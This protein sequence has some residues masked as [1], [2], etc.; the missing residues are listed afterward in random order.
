MSEGVCCL[1]LLE[2]SAM[3]ARVVCASKAMGEQIFGWIRDE[4][5]Q[6]IKEACAQGWDPMGEFVLYTVSHIAEHDANP[7]IDMYTDTNNLFHSIRAQA[8][9]NSISRTDG[10]ATAPDPGGQVHK[11]GGGVAHPDADV[12]ISPSPERVSSLTAAIKLGSPNALDVLLRHIKAR[13]QPTAFQ[14]LIADLILLA[15][16]GALAVVQKLLWAFGADPT[17]ISRRYQSS[18][19]LKAYTNPVG[20]VSRAVLNQLVTH[21]TRSNGVLGAVIGQDLL[22]YSEDAALRIGRVLRAGLD[23]LEEIIPVSPQGQGQIAVAS[24]ATMYKKGTMWF[25]TVELSTFCRNTDVLAT[26]FH[27]IIRMY[28]A[29]KVEEVILQVTGPLNEPPAAPRDQQLHMLEQTLV[30]AAKSCGFDDFRGNAEKEAIFRAVLKHVSPDAVTRAVQ[31]FQLQTFEGIK[32]TN[33]LPHAE[34]QVPSADPLPLQQFRAGHCSLVP[35]EGGM[36]IAITT[37]QPSGLLDA[38]RWRVYDTGRKPW[39]LLRTPTDNG[40]WDWVE[41]SRPLLSRRMRLSRGYTWKVEDALRTQE[42]D[43]VHPLMHQFLLLLTDVVYR[44]QNAARARASGLECDPERKH[45]LGSPQGG[46][47]GEGPS[48]RV[49]LAGYEGGINPLVINH[50]H[51][52]D[53]CLK[54]GMA[55]EDWRSPIHADNRK[56]PM[57]GWNFTCLAL[58]PG[59]SFK[60]SYGKGVCFYDE[61]LTSAWNVLPQSNTVVLFPQEKLHGTAPWNYN[62]ATGGLKYDTTWEPQPQQQQS[63]AGGS[64]CG[65]TGYEG[66]ERA[67]FSV[68][69]TLIVTGSDGVQYNHCDTESLLFEALMPGSC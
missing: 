67:S 36:R 59:P 34:L 60:P 12:M 54:V 18:A 52:H 19:I 8:E 4:K 65:S 45:E 15:V 63:K 64:S 69:G 29:A 3:D 1:G 39:V 53:Y 48:C 55:F 11:R 38:C 30:S 22:N 26:A 40:L 31:Q 10:I 49:E 32:V 24:G 6:E 37:T 44:V 46:A 9:R 50:F 66:V 47:A 41:S 17:T 23:P 56:V 35:H 61:E 33:V 43:P 25:S 58:E 42:L 13:M 27:S 51:L 57:E 2:C 21:D 62:P 16:D 5:V 14:A 20:Q 7:E 68:R 28:D